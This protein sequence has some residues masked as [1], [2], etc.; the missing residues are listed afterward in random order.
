MESPE[1]QAN[2]SL[3]TSQVSTMKIYGI[4]YLITNTANGKL[5][6]GQTKQSLRDRLSQHKSSS[7][8]FQLPLHR[9]FRKY[10]LDSFTVVEIEQCSSLVE[11]NQAETKWITYYSSNTRDLGYNC[12]SG[13]EKEFECS[14][15]TKLLISEARKRFM[16]DPRV[17]VSLSE[18]RKLY[19]S[20]HPEEVARLA[21]ISKSY[22]RS[23]EGRR[24][25]SEILLANLTNPEI[26]EH[27]RQSQSRRFSTPEGRSHILKVADKGRDSRWTKYREQRGA[28]VPED[29]VRTLIQGLTV[30]EYTTKRKGHPA[31]PKQSYFPSV[32]GK[33]F[34]EVRDGHRRGST[35]C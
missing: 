22:N 30:R 15:T 12:T 34:Q 35:R 17:R 31:L 32:Y 11:L 9:A 20:N 2:F 3:H 28:W 10:G 8:K 4:I 5:Y 33:T 16:A 23:S 29:E 19:L 21:S 26:K 25:H 27:Y 24:R 13:G 6:V 1:E 14:S 18:D 7:K